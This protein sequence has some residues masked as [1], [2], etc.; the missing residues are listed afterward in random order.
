M[1]FV[2][3]NLNLPCIFDRHSFQ[4][5]SVEVKVPTTDGLYLSKMLLTVSYGLLSDAAL[6][7]D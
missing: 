4:H 7:S 3:H 2:I 6:G 5:S 1:D